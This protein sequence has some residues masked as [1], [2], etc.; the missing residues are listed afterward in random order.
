MG[1]VKGFVCI[2][3][4]SNYAIV[5]EG[6]KSQAKPRLL[7]TTFGENFTYSIGQIYNDLTGY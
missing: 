1:R 2:F 5:Q 6:R 7:G 4:K 3:E